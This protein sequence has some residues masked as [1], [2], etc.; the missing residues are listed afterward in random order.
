M[1]KIIILLVFTFNVLA[2][3][4]AK[5]YT[6]SIHNP[7]DTIKG[8]PRFELNKPFIGWEIWGPSNILAL[9]YQQQLIKLGSSSFIDFNLIVNNET[10]ISHSMEY[11]QYSLFLNDYRDDDEWG[12]SKTALY[13]LF[14]KQLSKRISIELG[15]GYLHFQDWGFLKVTEGFPIHIVDIYKHN[16]IN[17]NALFRASFT[18]RAAKS[19]LFKFNL[20]NIIQYEKDFIPFTIVGVGKINASL[21]LLYG[22]NNVS[23]SDESYHFKKN[24][25]FFNLTKLQYGYEH[26]FLNSDK[27]NISAS[28]GITSFPFKRYGEYSYKRGWYLNPEVLLNFNYALNSKLYSFIG[29]GSYYHYVSFSVL[30]QIYNQKSYGFKTNLGLAFNI[31]ENLLLRIA[32]SPYYQKDININFEYMDRFKFLRQN[33]VN[34]SIAYSF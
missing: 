4:D 29:V 10:Y 6:D 12:V 28:I 2:Q 15:L 5:E 22:F 31:N 34:L 23:S 9:T 7:A 1:K 13:L 30:D 17:D 33:K 21:S 26:Y 18:L 24:Q 14:R 20:H 32:Y 8:Y 3:I 27:Y 25:F 19:I 16:Y 11:N